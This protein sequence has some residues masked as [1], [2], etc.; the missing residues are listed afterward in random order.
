MADEK[1][2]WARKRLILATTY[3]LPDTKFMLSATHTL[4]SLPFGIFLQNPLIIFSAAFVFH[5]FS[6][7]LLHWNIFPYKYKRYPFQLVTID[8]LAGLILAWMFVGNDLISLPVLAAIAGGNA[9]DVLSTLWDMTKQRQRSR[10]LIWAAPFF[11][12]HDRLQFETTN[13]AKGLISQ[14]ILVLLAALWINTSR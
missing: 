8:I 14:I 13:A 4:I 3:Q 1:T 10:W 9:P 5:L 6:D 12:F 2:A 7:T 11:N